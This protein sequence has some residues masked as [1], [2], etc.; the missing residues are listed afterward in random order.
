MSPSRNPTSRP[1]RRTTS[2]LPTR[3]SNIPSITARL[4]ATRAPCG[5]VGNADT[6]S[7]RTISATG[8]APAT[9]KKAAK[10][11]SAP[12]AAAE[13]PAPEAVEADTAEAPAPEVR[14]AKEAA[15]AGLKAEPKADAALDASPESE[16]KE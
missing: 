15:A 16:S 9:E 11:E 6:A 7:I 4:P 14:Q 10:A 5:S 1:R 12:E 2:S 13:T 3:C 8:K